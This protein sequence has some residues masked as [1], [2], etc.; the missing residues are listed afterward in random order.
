[1]RPSRGEP[2]VA[3]DRAGMTVFRDITFLAAG[4][5]SERRRWASKFRP[6]ST[7]HCSR[8]LASASSLSSATTCSNAR[9]LRRR[10]SVP[11]VLIAL[12][13]ILPGEEIRY[14]YSTTMGAGCWTI[15]CLCGSK[16]CRGLIADFHLLAAEI[17]S[18]YLR[19]G[20]VQRCIVER[21]RCVVAAGSAINVV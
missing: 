16:E 2:P 13:D 12:R 21:M 3:L 15:Q 18:E 4:P 9:A 17:Q 7:S 5:A 14:D 8:P 11:G 19:L 1:M 20:I 10:L 6:S